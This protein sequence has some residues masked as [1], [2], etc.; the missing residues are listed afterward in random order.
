MNQHTPI[1]LF[2]LLG[3]IFHILIG[4]STAQEPKLGD[5]GDGNRSVPVHWI[6]LF[7]QDSVLVRPGDTVPMP[8]STKNTCQ[9]ECHDYARIEVGWHFNAW[10]PDVPAGRRGEPWVLADP[11]TATQAP[12][13]HR[14]WE[15]IFR[16]EVFGLTP[17][18]FTETF[19]R[20]GLGGG[21]SEN[22]STEDVDTF[23]RWRVSGKA[24]INCLACHDGEFGHDQA[25][26]HRQMQ[27]QN[28]RWAAAATSAF[29][30][31]TGAARN[32]PINYDVYSGVVHD[33]QNA[34]APKVE[35][36]KSRFDS[37]G[38]IFF[39]IRR[40][41]QNERC[42]FCHSSKYT[43]GEVWDRW[44]V[45]EDV[46][47][48]AGL[49]CVDCH[50]NGL[51][52]MITRGYEWEAEVRNDPEV[53]TLTCRGCHMR[54]QEDDYPANGR[55][56]APYPEH[57]GLPTI[58]FDKLSCTACHSGPVPD[59]DIGRVKLSRTHALGTHG[60]KKG[61]NVVPYIYSPVMALDEDGK[62]APQRLMWPSFWAFENE[63]ELTPIEPKKFQ[64][65]VLNVV[66]TDSLTDS[67][68]IA[69]MIAG[70]WANFSEAQTVQ[71]LDSLKILFPEAGVPVYVG[72]GKIFKAENGEI[73]ASSGNPA[74]APYMW[75]FAHDVRPAEQSLGIRRCED[76]HATD[77]PFTFATVKAEIPFSFSTG[78]EIDIV[79]LQG[80]D[81]I[82]PRV[83]A[84][85]FL[86]RP[87]FKILIIAC[88]VIILFVLLYGSVRGTESILKSW[89]GQNYRDTF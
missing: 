63:G 5:E 57:R 72:G 64:R 84:F 87:F 80:M 66:Q 19:G 78:E 89:S 71:I 53:S 20:H 59:T 61:D 7:D 45:D 39:D 1:R 17:F 77:A 62:I 4:K 48:S 55:L 40:N 32:M 65:M 41:V 58:H 33:I 36:D 8:F 24:E 83:F 81:S 9:Q 29:A 3:C 52:H 51:D 60:V 88:C 6:N 15:R 42:Y 79:S 75:A 47:L 30:I 46:H 25:E 56:G 73:I 21:I 11:V 34:R 49:T 44:H 14:D 18:Y 13:S 27:F 28:F 31:V 67:L 86:F 12:V 54:E 2:L 82:Y 16:P 70:N 35:Y 68:K 22:D 26:Y 23:M 10:N 76:C 37:Q 69:S 74:A 43:G 85:T 38:K 50:R